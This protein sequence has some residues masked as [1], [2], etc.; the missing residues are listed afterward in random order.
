MLYLIFTIPVI[1]LILSVFKIIEYMLLK[2]KIIEKINSVKDYD[3]ISFLSY[4]I[5]ELNKFSY[6]FAHGVFKKHRLKLIA[7]RNLY[8]KKYANE[9]FLKM[10]RDEQIIV[11]SSYGFG[12]S[13]AVCCFIC[14]INAIATGTLYLK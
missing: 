6:F 5:F 14:K 9:L 2:A 11:L 10:I 8:V 4:N 7:K 12:I 3:A 13:F 1:F